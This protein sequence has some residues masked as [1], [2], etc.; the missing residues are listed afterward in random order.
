MP[1][2]TPEVIMLAIGAVTGIWLINNLFTKWAKDIG[3]YY[4][5]MKITLTTSKTPAEVHRAMQAAVRKRRFLQ[6]VIVLSIWAVLAWKFPD[7]RQ[8]TIEG[9]SALLIAIIKAAINL[10]QYF[11]EAINQFLLQRG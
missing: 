2:L 9:V 5:P 4:G 1:P 6:I 11:L 10:L 3:S 8:R 7:F